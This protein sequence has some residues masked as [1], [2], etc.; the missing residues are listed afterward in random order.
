MVVCEMCNGTYH[1]ACLNPPLDDVPEYDWQCYICQAHQIEGVIDC[2]DDQEKAGTKIRHQALGFD[3][4]GNKYW[5]LCRRMFIEEASG[6]IRY[7]TSVPQFEELM[8]ALDD[9]YF[10]ADVA[11]A[12]EVERTEIERQMEL[13][14]KLT[15]ELKPKPSQKS[16]LELENRKYHPQI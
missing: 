15:K 7:Y 10:E 9:K 8:E 3:R 4:S 2:V 1:L 5:F 6:N 14:E 12:I 11:N 13:T 16:Y